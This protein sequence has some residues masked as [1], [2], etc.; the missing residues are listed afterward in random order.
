MAFGS[1][2][3]SLAWGCAGMGSNKPSE[4]PVGVVDPQRILAETVK[5]KR[6]SDAL[7]AFMKDRQT[8]VELE[9]RELRKLES[10]LM[11]QSTV[12]SQE[13]RDRKEEQ[14]RAKMAGYQQ[15]VADLNREVQEKQ[16]ELQNEFR[17]QVQR[18]V[19]EVAGQRGLGLV[20]E[21]GVNSGTLFFEAGL[22]ISTDVIQALDRESGAIGVP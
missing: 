13:A 21:Y 15:K 1:L 7:N 22:D 12:L 2:V 11:A 17:L 4:L 9:Q 20:L 8:L 19:T 5:G 6:L 3:L 18:V 16:Q 10:E 14:F